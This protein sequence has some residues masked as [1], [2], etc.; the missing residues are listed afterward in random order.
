MKP[1]SETLRMPNGIYTL[2]MTDGN[3]STMYVNG[4][5][6]GKLLETVI[7]HELCHCWCMTEGIRLDEQTEEIVAQFL[8]Q[9]G[10]DIF[11][12]ADGIF[13]MLRAKIS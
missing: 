12:I 13:Q 3:T 5:V 2:G 10:K 8:A 11:R 9:Y 4:R 6:K 1:D 7:C